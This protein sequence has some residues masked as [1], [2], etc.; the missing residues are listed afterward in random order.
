MGPPWEGTKSAKV[1]PTPLTVCLDQHIRTMH[2]RPKRSPH[3]YA[4]TDRVWYSPASAHISYSQPYYTSRT[5][6]LLDAQ[7]F[8]P[9]HTRSGEKHARDSFC[10]MGVR[11]KGAHARDDRTRR[12]ALHCA[13]LSMLRSRRRYISHEV[14][15][16]T[17]GCGKRRLVRR[18]VA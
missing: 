13:A 1:A 9:S 16:R 6:R 11:R 15:T 4:K 14:R 5:L 2:G 3:L 8:P 10:G 7:S 12:D 18:C 17:M